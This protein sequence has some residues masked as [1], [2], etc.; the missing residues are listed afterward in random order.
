[1]RRHGKIPKEIQQLRLISPKFE[2]QGADLPRNNEGNGHKV[3]R[4]DTLL[5]KKEEVVE[6]PIRGIIVPDKKLGNKVVYFK[7]SKNKNNKLN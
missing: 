6:I 7:R 4:H 5:S 2:I 3:V 1:M